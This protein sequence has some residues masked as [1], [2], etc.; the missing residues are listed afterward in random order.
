ME[1]GVPPYYFGE[2]RTGFFDIKPLFYPDS[3]LPLPNCT[4]KDYTRELSLPYEGEAQ[5]LKW[6]LKL[7]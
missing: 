5:A 1:P 2:E 4:W 6:R 7:R 3:P